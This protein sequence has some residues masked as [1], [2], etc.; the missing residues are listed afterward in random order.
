MLTHRL[1]KSLMRLQWIVT[2][3][4]V[5][6]RRRRRWGQLPFDVRQCR[7]CLYWHIGE[8]EPL[9]VVELAQDFVL[10]QIEPIAHA[11]PATINHQCYCVVGVASLSLAIGP[12]SLARSAARG[13]TCYVCQ[14]RQP[15]KSR[16]SRKGQTRAVSA[17]QRLFDFGQSYRQP[18]SHFYEKTVV[19]LFT[20][21]LWHVS[22]TMKRV[23]RLSVYRFQHSLQLNNQPLPYNLLLGL[24]FGKLI[25]VRFYNTL[26][27]ARCKA[28]YIICIY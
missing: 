2:R 5:L 15:A 12:R 16:I 19:R 6:A 11:K 27:Y 18:D 8:R 10:A 23:T 24:T 9:L 26:Y 20:I 1:A 22:L 7:R 21:S 3:M 25:L 14:I 4:H 17:S 13:G 28:L